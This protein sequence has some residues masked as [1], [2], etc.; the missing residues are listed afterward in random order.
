[1]SQLD[2]EL[3]P[4]Q[5][6]RGR[7]GDRSYVVLTLEDAGEKLSVG[8]RKLGLAH[9]KGLE[10]LPVYEIVDGASLDPASLAEIPGERLVTAVERESAG[11]VIGH[12]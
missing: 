2:R 6:C 7:D 12:I 10:K 5:L 9:L 11:A 3:K 4:G 8:V 1:I